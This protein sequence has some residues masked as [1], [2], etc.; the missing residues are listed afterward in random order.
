MQLSGSMVAIVTPFKNGAI[1]RA[2]YKNLIEFQDRERDLRD[3][4]LRDDRESATLTND[5]H[6]ALIKLTVELVAGRVPVIAGTGS[7]ST[8]EALELTAEAK[9]AGA[10]AALLIT[11]Y[12]NKPPRKGFTVTTDT[13]PSR[14]TSR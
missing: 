12:Y 14:W 11:P 10:D 5:E 9:A 8:V 1:D 4:P 3:H 6:E 7:N 13:S 2:A